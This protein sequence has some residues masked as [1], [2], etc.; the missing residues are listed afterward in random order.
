MPSG[1]RCAAAS[2]IFRSTSGLTGAPSK[3]TIPQMPLIEASFL[4]PWPGHRESLCLIPFQGRQRSVTFQLVPADHNA[5]FTLH[6]GVS[7][8]GTLVVSEGTDVEDGRMTSSS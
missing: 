2:A 5:V 8:E 7:L 6:P 4:A 3:L 1:P